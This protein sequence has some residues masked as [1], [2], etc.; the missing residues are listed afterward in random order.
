MVPPEA[1]KGKKYDPKGV[2]AYM[3]GRIA[4]QVLLLTPYSAYGNSIDID[5]TNELN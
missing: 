2:N 4:L 1:R 3:L 5:P